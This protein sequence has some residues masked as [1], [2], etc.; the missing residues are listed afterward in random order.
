MNYRGWKVIDDPMY[1]RLIKENINFID[2]DVKE[3]SVII[4]K[5]V[6]QRAVA[7]D[8]GC[9]YGFF[10]K[11]LSQQFETVHAFDFN[12][13]I[14]ECFKENMKKFKCKNVIA[15]PHG[16]GEKQKYVATKDWSEKHNRRGP[17][18][19]HIDPDGE[20]KNQKIKK[21]DSFNLKNVG[22]IMMDTEGYELNVLKGAHKTIKKFKPVL[23]MEFHTTWNNRF[24][25]LTG[26]FGYDLEQLQ[27]YVEN[28]GYRSIGYINKV[29]QVFVSK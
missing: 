19:N 8:I 4:D 27:A 18:S 6:K 16:L 25:N 22:L 1:D 2:N 11:F 15:Y 7:V 10:T 26:R 17:L 12:N 21:L 13:D 9:H 29:D 20:I 3:M 23:V 5:H 14:F 24:N 28:L